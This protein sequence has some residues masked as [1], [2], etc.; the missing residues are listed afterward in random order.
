MPKY[1]PPFTTNIILFCLLIS[2]IYND[3]TIKF[4]LYVYVLE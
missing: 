3:I 2:S 1:K 4:V